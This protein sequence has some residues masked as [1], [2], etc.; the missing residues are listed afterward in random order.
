VSPAAPEAATQANARRPR[1]DA[2]VL[3]LAATALELA[4][5]RE[6]LQGARETRGP[7]DAVTL[8]SLGRTP[9]A[10][11][12]TGI[13][14]ANAAACLAATTQALGPRAAVQVGIGGA[15]LGSF[16]SN[17]MVAAAS[18]ELQ[19]DLGLRREDGGLDGLDLLGFAATP[20]REG[21]PA[22]F[23][24]V[25]TH[26]GLQRVLAERIGLP[27]LRFATLDAITA[28]VDRGAALQR[29]HDVSIESMEG[30]AAAQVADRL[31]LPFAEVRGVSNLVGERDKRLWDIRSA[32]QASCRAVRALVEGWDDHPTTQAMRGSAVPGDSW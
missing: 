6:H 10:L 24:L 2:P 19:L 23:N 8:G 13:G 20:E 9:V 31:G 25:P 32:V 30:A 14:K 17:G 29:A 16:L 15:Y 7:W 28:G 11:A 3:V 26:E 18:E 22:R 4:P 27:L 5:L 1:D 12:V 21:R